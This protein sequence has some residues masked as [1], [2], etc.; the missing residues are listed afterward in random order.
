MPTERS[1]KSLSRRAFLWN[2]GATAGAL[3]LS[4]CVAPAAPEAAETGASGAEAPV[5][6]TYT[7]YSSGV[8]KELWDGIIAMF[9]EK[10]PNIEVTYLPIPGDSWGEYFDKVSTMIAGGNAPDVVRVAIE[11]ILLF[12]SRGLALPIDDLIEGDEEI[13]APMSGST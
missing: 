5:A 9:Q 13:A 12:V 8:D 1:R 4:G 7:N 10:T 6:I 3:A 11:G 2:L